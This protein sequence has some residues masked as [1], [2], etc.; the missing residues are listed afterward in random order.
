MFCAREAL[1]LL[2]CTSEEELDAPE[3]EDEPPEAEDGEGGGEDGESE[4]PPPASPMAV[5]PAVAIPVVLLDERA[6]LRLRHR[7]AAARP[8]EDADELVG[9]EEAVAVGI[10]LGERFAQLSR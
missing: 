4:P 5:E 2:R 7:F 8:G 10:E 3:V 6:R 9:G 1:R